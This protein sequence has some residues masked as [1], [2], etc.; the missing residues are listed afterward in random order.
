MTGD[1]T[2]ASPSYCCKVNEVRNSSMTTICVPDSG[3]NLNCIKRNGTTCSKYSFDK[4]QPAFANCAKSINGTSCSLCNFGY[5]LNNSNICT[6][7]ETLNASCTSNLISIG[8]L[9][10]DGS[11]NCSSCRPNHQL[12]SNTCCPYGSKWSSS[13]KKCI[14]LSDNCAK[15]DVGGDCTNCFLD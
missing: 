10:E 8:C 13:A 2:K 3:V 12:D 1:A 5:V 9:K 4:T 14:T 6:L 15:V 7:T 11:C